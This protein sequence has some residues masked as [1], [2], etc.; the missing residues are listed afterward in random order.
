MQDKELQA[1]KLIK[2]LRE[3]CVCYGKYIQKIEENNEKEIK[4]VNPELLKIRKKIE[5][6]NNKLENSYYNLYL[7]R[8]F[9]E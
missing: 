3:L 5:N 7:E 2:G 6:K 4:G 8:L 9:N 1:Q